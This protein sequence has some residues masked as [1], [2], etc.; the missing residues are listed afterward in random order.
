MGDTPSVAEL[1]KKT[2]L[3][4]GQRREI[5]QSIDSAEHALRNQEQLRSLGVGIDADMV[6]KM[7]ARDKETLARGTPSGYE[8]S[9]KNQMFRLMKHLE[10]SITYDMPTQEDMERPTPANI[11]KHMAWEEGHKPEVLAWRTIRR[12]LDPDNDRANFTSIETLRTNT[13]PKG[14]PRRYWRNFD[15][16]QWEEEIEE[17]LVENIDD[18]EYLRFLEMRVLNWAKPNVL[19]ELQWSEGQYAAALERFRRASNVTDADVDNVRRADAVRNEA[20]EEPRAAAKPKVKKKPRK[21]M[22]STVWPIPI[23]REMGLVSVAPITRLTGIPAIRFTKECLSEKAKGW[24]AEE[25]HQLEKALREWD[26]A[27][28]FIGAPQKASM[29][30]KE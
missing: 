21:L 6:A 5:Q 4:P 7:L 29:E 13:P 14:D 24:S 26:E 9:T 16:I 2:Y 23:L 12:V 20:T 11:D 17:D 19:R 28:A 27:H 30:E 8:G 1:A 15:H 25:R 18:R 3:R 22:D 10:R